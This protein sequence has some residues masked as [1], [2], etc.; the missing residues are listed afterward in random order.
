ME[1]MVVVLLRIANNRIL[2]I[3]ERERLSLYNL[4]RPRTIAI[5][6]HPAIQS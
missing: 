1:D 6:S 4:D 5:Y 2:C 3:E